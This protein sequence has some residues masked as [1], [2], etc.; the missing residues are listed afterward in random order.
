MG[1]KCGIVGLPN[2]GKSTL[3]NALTKAGIAAENYPFCTIEPNV[4]IVPVPD[5]R[6]QVLETMVKPERVLPATMEFVD[7][8]GIV[9]GASKG[10]GLGN[11]F[12]AHI[13]EAQAIAQVVRCFES[14]DIIHV[15][16]KVDPLSDLEVIN[17]EL[18]LADMESLEKA[19]VRVEKPAKAGDKLALAKKPVIQ[20]ALAGTHEGKLVRELGLSDD[21]QA[22]L[23]DLH[24]LTIKPMMLI[25]N[26][27]ED[28]FENNPLLDAVRARAVE[29]GANVVPVCAAIEAEISQLDDDEK[30]MFLAEMGLEE[31]GLNR[32]IRAGYELLG[33]QTYFTAGVKEV[34]AWTIPVGATAPQ[35]AGV[36][37]TDFERG[38]IR[39][40]VMSYDDFVAYKGEAGCKE[41]GKLRLEG[42]E[43]LV[44]DGDIMH[45][46]FN[47]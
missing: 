20:Q 44:K 35:A 30:S 14:D 22:L 10:E 45:F 41:V 24:L 2:V 23:Q 32:I 42:K 19:L 9:A 13:R 36:I 27:A 47:V 31:P 43:Y 15:A 34:R 3:F 33:F 28:G 18:V 38:F 1:F 16:G 11:K 46:R 17:T 5:P 25:A 37:H 6:L 26:V 40:E 7:I 12:L 39:A 29:L 21:E 4:G 8:A